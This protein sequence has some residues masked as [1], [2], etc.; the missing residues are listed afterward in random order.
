M[1][2]NLR[3]GGGRYVPDTRKPNVAFIQRPISP[4]CSK[5]SFEN[6]EN[7]KRLERQ[8]MRRSGGEA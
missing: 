3:K 4:V 8:S 2:N 6:K 7:N 1:N 5:M